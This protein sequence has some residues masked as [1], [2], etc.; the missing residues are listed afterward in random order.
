MLT[1]SSDYGVR[2]WDMSTMSASLRPFKELKPFDG[3]PVNSLSFSGDPQ[4]S[5]FLACCG[6]NQARVFHNDGSKLKTTVRGDMYIQDLA[7]TKGHVA[8]ITA[9]QFHPKDND[10]F[11]TSSLD[12]TVR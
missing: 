9:G 2:I 3:Y 11:V 6:N 12:G 10:T 8:T 5:L 1:G 4:A 7:N